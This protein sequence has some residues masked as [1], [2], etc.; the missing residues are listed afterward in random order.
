M[1]SLRDVPADLRDEL[2][3]AGLD[4]DHVWET[5]SRAVH[6]DIP[7]P[8]WTTRLARSTI[9]ADARGEAVLAARQPGVVA[10]LGVA[11]LTFFMLGADATVTDRV[12]DGTHVE[13][14]DVV[15]R[16]TGL[17]QRML[18]A[19]RAQAAGPRADRPDR[20]H[21]PGKPRRRPRARGLDQARH[22]GGRDHGG[23]GRAAADREGVS[24][25]CDSA[26]RELA[27]QLD[28][29]PERDVLADVELVR[30][31][32]VDRRGRETSRRPAPRASR[33]L[34]RPT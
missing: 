32:V 20:A 27:A 30:L 5:L 10:G 16:V 19:E 9:S 12:P 34:T 28:R 1:T 13:E 8:G 3:A 7:T 17:T 29:Q 22:A 25:Y 2:V 24:P 26:S 6:E 23:L 14:G 18:V 15:M 21:A 11:A 4:L 33:A 31:D